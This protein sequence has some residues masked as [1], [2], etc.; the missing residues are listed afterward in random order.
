MA[1]PK[2]PALTSQPAWLAYSYYITTDNGW[3]WKRGGALGVF[4][5][6]EDA[7]VCFDTTFETIDDEFSPVLEGTV[8]IGTGHKHTIRLERVSLY[9]KEQPGD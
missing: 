3:A 4:T 1:K 7:A 5:S 2:S 8:Y 9:S 6:V